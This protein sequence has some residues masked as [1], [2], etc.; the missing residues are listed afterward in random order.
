M[1]DAKGNMVAN[2]Q[3][4]EAPTEGEDDRSPKEMEPYLKMPS[5]DYF[6]GI[7]KRTPRL[8]V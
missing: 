2:P 7:I 1:R 3:F 4:R 6:F 5:F 8:Q